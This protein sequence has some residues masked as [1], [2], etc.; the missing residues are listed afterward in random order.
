VRKVRKKVFAHFADGNSHGFL[1]THS[2]TRL[3]SLVF[4]KT[5]PLATP[6]VSSVLG[7][8]CNLFS[9]IPFTSNPGQSRLA[10]SEDFRVKL[11]PDTSD[12][13]GSFPCRSVELPEQQTASQAMPTNRSSRTSIRPLLC[14]TRLLA[15]VGFLISATL[16]PVSAVLSSVI[17]RLHNHFPT[18]PLVSIPGYSYSATS[19]ELQRKLVP[20]V[21]DP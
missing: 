21:P 15:A 11:A 20:G 4:E 8:R 12:S 9:T 2:L 3:K 7:Q 16:P 10:I 13:G 19:E 18:R 5:P 17:T 1:H 6:S 14:I